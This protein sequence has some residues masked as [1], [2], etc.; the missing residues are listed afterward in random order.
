MTIVKER[1]KLDDHLIFMLL[2]AS[3]QNVLKLL[4]FILLWLFLYV[5][6]E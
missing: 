2:L 6:Y 4:F 3:M 1:E 5:E